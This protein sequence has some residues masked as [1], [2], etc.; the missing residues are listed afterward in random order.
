MVNTYTEIE[1]MTANGAKSSTRRN[2]DCRQQINA[3][4][5]THGVHYHGMVKGDLKTKLKD[6]IWETSYLKVR[7]IIAIVH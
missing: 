5:T 4:P 3:V 2:L 7:F 6:P 1:E